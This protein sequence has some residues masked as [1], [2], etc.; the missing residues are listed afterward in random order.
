MEQTNLD[1]QSMTEPELL[2]ACGTDAARWAAAF[3]QKI[4]DAGKPIDEGLMIGWFANAIERARD[5]E[6]ERQRRRMGLK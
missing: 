3:Q 6:N 5:D 4:V 2:Q 1:Y